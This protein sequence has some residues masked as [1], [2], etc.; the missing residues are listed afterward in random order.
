M[1]VRDPVLPAATQPRHPFHQLL[2]VPHLHVLGVQTDLDPLA[3]QS[4]RHRVRVPLDV[5]RAAR[6]HLH[7]DAARR[8]EPTRRQRS[9]VFH[10]LG[11]LRTA[12]RVEL[13]EQVAEVV[14]VRLAGGEVPAPPEHQLLVEG[15]LEPPVSLLDVPVLVAATGLDRLAFE[16][17]VLQQRLIPLGE[18]RTG[19]A[20]RD[21]GGEPIGA[22]NGGHAAELS[23]RVLQPVGQRLERL[24]EAHR[25]S[26]PVRE[27]EDE[28]VDQ[29]VE[30]PTINGHPQVGHVREVGGTQ[31]AGRVHLGE[32]HFLRWPVARPPRLDPTLERAELAVRETT[33]VFPLE[34]PEQGQRLQSGV[35]GEPLDD[36]VPD[37]VEGVRVSPPGMGHPYLGG[38]PGEPAVLAC[39]LGI[40]PRPCGSEGGGCAARVELPQSTNLLIRGEH[41]EPSTTW[42]RSA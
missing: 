21:R 25:A 34:L 10:L 4:A 17:V 1:P 24:G 14:L 29:V 37:A 28:V 31:T 19:R 3:D 35:E 33:G 15:L 9:E 32:E 36:A 13:C 26:L 11:L 22:V 23:Q 8:L 20:R 16:A 39:G 40:H 27:G 7:L 18:L 30:R 41:D 2:R 38:K 42:V 12:I 6:I 5:D